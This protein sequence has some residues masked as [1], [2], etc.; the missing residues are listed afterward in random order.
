MD[1][2]IPKLLVRAQAHR[3]K[4]SPPWVEEAWAKNCRPREMSLAGVG[5][6]KLALAKQ[7]FEVIA[8]AELNIKSDIEQERMKNLWFLHSFL[9]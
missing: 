6:K 1:S 5:M 7:I 3:C 2:P 9:V 8:F 4:N